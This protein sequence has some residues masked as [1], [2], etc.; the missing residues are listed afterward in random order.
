LGG[1]V[2][3]AV[4]AV[5]VALLLFLW[6]PL[7]PLLLLLLPLPLFGPVDLGSLCGAFVV[8]APDAPYLAAVA[9]T[10]TS[11]TSR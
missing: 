5:V 4:S 1:V 11:C 8:V 2:V 6:L 9:R 7:G 3:V 10:C